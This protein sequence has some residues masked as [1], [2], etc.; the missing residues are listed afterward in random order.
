[1]T[2]Q[3]FEKRF[4]ERV[5]AE[6][7]GVIF[8]SENIPDGLR[9]YLTLSL[10]VF[11]YHSVKC[12]LEEYEQVA[13]WAAEGGDMPMITAFIAL[14]ITRGVSAK[15]IGVNLMVYIEMNKLLDDMSLAWDVIVKPTKERINRELNEEFE[16]EYRKQQA[17]Q[18]LN[19]KGNKIHL[20]S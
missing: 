11:T 15:D 14:Q 19:R 12:T 4:N 18:A 8:P 2:Q 13:M 17:A 10:P 5:S 20:P 6:I 1:M 7:N 9:D 16:R 3:D